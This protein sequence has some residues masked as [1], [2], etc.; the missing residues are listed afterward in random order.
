M[1]VADEFNDSVRALTGGETL[2]FQAIEPIVPKEGDWPLPSSSARWVGPQTLTNGLDAVF[3]G[4]PR[5]TGD[6]VLRSARVRIVVGGSRVFEPMVNEGETGPYYELFFADQSAVNTEQ[7]IR[8]PGPLRVEP[9]FPTG[10]LSR[11]GVAL[12]ADEFLLDSVGADEL[13]RLELIIGVLW[14]LADDPNLDE[15]DKSRIQA[16][17]VLLGDLQRSEPDEVKRFQVIGV[18]R[19]LLVGLRRLGGKA[20]GP[21]VG[22]SLAQVLNH[23]GYLETVAQL[24][25]HASS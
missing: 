14:K 2:T 20:I 4:I 18:I 5:V 22:A 13:A 7:V 11:V 1:S 25:P 21:A 23:A 12:D 10:T 15:G 19:S 6:G 3:D 17:A 8:A 9:E 24:L 16:A